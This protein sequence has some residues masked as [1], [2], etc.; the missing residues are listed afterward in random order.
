M[1]NNKSKKQGKKGAGG[2]DI[3]YQNK[4]V[5]SKVMA[6]EFKGKSLGLWHKCSRDC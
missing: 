4:D 2:S 5:V 3:T 1:T 6:E